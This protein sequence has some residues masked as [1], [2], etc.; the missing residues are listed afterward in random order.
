MQTKHSRLLADIER[1]AGDPEIAE[2]Y[3]DALE[4]RRRE[5]RYVCYWEPH[6]GQKAFWRNLR[7]EQKVWL[8]LG[9]NRSGKTSFASW[10]DAVWL[11]GKDYFRNEVNWQWVDLLPVPEGPT[12]VRVVGLVADQLRDPLWEKLMGFS[13]HPP[14]LPPSEV[15]DVNNTLFVARLKNGSHLAGKSAETDPKK[16]GGASCDLVHID[17]ECPGA[18]FDENYQR[19][20][21]KGGKLLVTAT[22]LDDPGTSSRPWLFDLVEQWKRG[23]PTIGVTYLSALDNPYTPEEEKRKLIARWRG[24]PEERARLYGEFVRR[25]GLY[26]KNWRFEPPLW[27]PARALPRNGLRVVMID[28]AV[29]GTVGALWAHFDERGHMTLYRSY[30]RA[31]L[32]VS[33]HVAN[34]LDENRGDPVHMWFCDPWMGKQSVPSAHSQHQTVLQVWRDAGLP[35]LR[36]PSIDYELALARSHEYIRAS[37]DPTDPHPGLT[38]FDH[39]EDW[40]H[41]IKSYVIDSVAQGPRRGEMRDRPRKGDST[42]MECFQYL[43]GLRLQF[44]PSRPQMAPASQRSYFA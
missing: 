29:T 11:L 23:D 26:Y 9:G 39:L 5:Q 38:V 20:V 28:P 2:L 25:S 34:L 40:E 8:V 15:S 19:T 37:D 31:G 21:S 12:S 14:F 43:A 30:K 1:Q 7:P 35:R 42:L 13:E 4:A 36:L 3:L 16:H 24:H 44:T 22:P 32:S 17:E 41:E 6:A 18:I 33:Q 10:L 27:V